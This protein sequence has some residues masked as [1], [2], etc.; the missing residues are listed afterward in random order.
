MRWV[1]KQE[2]WL[3]LCL[4]ILLRDYNSRPAEYEVVVLISQKIHL[5]ETTNNEVVGEDLPLP[6]CFMQESTER[7][8]FG[9]VYGEMPR[10]VTF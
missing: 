7:I 6:S 4:P 5:D 10:N 3:V 9:D 1:S 8:A 2:T